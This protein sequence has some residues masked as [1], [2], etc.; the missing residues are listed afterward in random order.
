MQECVYQT[1]A[2]DVTDL[3]QHLTD[4]RYGLPQSIVD[5]AIAVEE[6]RTRL[7]A[8]VKD[9]EGHFEHLL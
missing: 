1:P 5:D 4:T 7:R 2:E 6:W 8:C 9:K 3:K